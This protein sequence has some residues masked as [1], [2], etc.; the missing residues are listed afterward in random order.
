MDEAAVSAF[1]TLE[2]ISAATL[3]PDFVR[4]PRIHRCW[5]LQRR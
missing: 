5:K 1:A 3:G 2:D 4:N